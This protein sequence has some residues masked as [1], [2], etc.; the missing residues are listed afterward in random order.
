M[1]TRESLLFATCYQLSRLIADDWEDRPSAINTALDLLKPID[2]PDGALWGVG[3]HGANRGEL[4]PYETEPEHVRKRNTVIG[5]NTVLKAI[6][7]INEHSCGWQTDDSDNLKKEL[8]LRKHDYE[9][10]LRK[11]TASQPES[12]DITV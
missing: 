5:L 12:C 6:S 10:E 9:K 11:L 8:A 2:E 4:K 7:I 1:I 3:L